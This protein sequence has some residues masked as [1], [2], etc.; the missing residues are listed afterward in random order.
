MN[1]KTLNDANI[2]NLDNSF[3]YPNIKLVVNDFDGKTI[4]Q[5]TFTLNNKPIHKLEMKTNI[6]NQ[7]NSDST[8]L[9]Y[10][11]LSGVYLRYTD[12]NVIVSFFRGIKE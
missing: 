4:K 9:L 1:S 3:H 8:W 6:S 11:Y 7:V 5:S 10:E 2:T 12:C